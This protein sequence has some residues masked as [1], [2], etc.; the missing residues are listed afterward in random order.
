MEILLQSRYQSSDFKAIGLILITMVLFSVSNL[1]VKEVGSIYPIVQIS[2]IRFSLIIPFIILINFRETGEIFPKSKNYKLQ[3]LCGLLATAFLWFL[4][5]SFQ[6]LPL[7]D[8]Q[9]IAFSSSLF[10]TLLAWPLIGEKAGFHR[11]FAV[12]VGFVGVLIVAN[13]DFGNI[14]VGIIFGITSS[15]LNALYV[16]YTRKATRD[17]SFLTCVFYS[18]LVAGA[19]LGVTLPFKWMAPSSADWGYLIMMGMLGGVGQI[20]ITTAFGRGSPTLLS[21]FFYTALI[22]GMIFDFMFWDHTPNFTMIM[23]ASIIIM[24]CIYVTY[25]ESLSAR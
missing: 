2:F 19:I 24:S 8:A 9:S 7:A 22:W 12:F 25:R 3:I 21:P 1:I 4:F 14:N 18:S 10:I 15:F 11:I 16:I 13:P 5:K 20:L 6:T 23:G 17:D